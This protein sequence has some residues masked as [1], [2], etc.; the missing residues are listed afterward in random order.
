MADT[1]TTNYTKATIPITPAGTCTAKDASH[2]YYEYTY[3]GNAGS[4]ISTSACDHKCYHYNFMTNE[5]VYFSKNY[6]VKIKY[7]DITNPIGS[8]CSNFE[9]NKTAVPMYCDFKDCFYNDIDN[10]YEQNAVGIVPFDD[11]VPWTEEV[12]DLI[13]VNY[14]HYNLYR[15]SYTEGNQ[16]ITLTRQDVFLSPYGLDNNLYTDFTYV[17]VADH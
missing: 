10:N 1:A 9:E 15:S 4:Q 5:T 13:L 14:S 2:P 7:R 3:A 16:N 17:R 12:G 11:P 8:F 6:N